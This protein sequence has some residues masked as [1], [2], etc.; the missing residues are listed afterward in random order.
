MPR[1]LLERRRSPGLE[2]SGMGGH[3]LVKGRGSL[4]SRVAGP[5]GHTAT[6]SCC[7]GGPRSP[8]KQSVIRFDVFRR[9]CLISL[10]P[11]SKRITLCG[12]MQGAPPDRQAVW[13]PARVYLPPPSNQP[14]HLAWARTIPLPT[15]ATHWPPGTRDNTSAQ[16]RYPSLSSTHGKCW[17]QLQFHGRCSVGTGLT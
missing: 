1:R 3:G 13:W 12:A 10:H 16:S 4:E 9:N 17:K 15:P 8:L 7:A 14:N 6:Q 2:Q 11:H 5:A